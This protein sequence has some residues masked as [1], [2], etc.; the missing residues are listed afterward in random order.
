MSREDYGEILTVDELAD[1]LA[2]A[3]GS[4]PT[5]SRIGRVFDTDTP[6]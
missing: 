3:T 1:V 4:K 2:D 5:A 6:R